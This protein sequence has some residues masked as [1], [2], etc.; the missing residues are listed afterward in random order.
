LLTANGPT[1]VIFYPNEDGDVL[2]I[3]ADILGPGKY[4]SDWLPNF[5]ISAFLTLLDLL[6]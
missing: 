1:G 4:S 5:I 6:Q 2:D 3:Q